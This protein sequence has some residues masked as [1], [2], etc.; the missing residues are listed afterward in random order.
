[1]THILPNYHVA[2]KGTTFFK[3]PLLRKAAD[4]VR[5]FLLEEVFR[6]VEQNFPET[7]TY[8]VDESKVLRMGVHAAI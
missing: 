5:A 7:S 6:R 8:H 2:S 1:M 3:V 4:Y